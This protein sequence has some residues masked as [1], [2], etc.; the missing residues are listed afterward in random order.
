MGFSTELG[1]VAEEFGRWPFK[2]Q[3]SDP[4]NELYGIRELVDK[5]RS[6]RNRERSFV[7]LPVIG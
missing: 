4:R 5:E 2:H 6:E 1:Q 3:D 7:K